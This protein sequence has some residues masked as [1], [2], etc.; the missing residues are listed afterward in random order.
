MTRQA[1]TTVGFTSSRGEQLEGHLLRLARREVVFEVYGPDDV[2]RASEVL[3]KLIVKSGERTVYDGKATVAALVNKPGALTCKVVLD[4]KGIDASGLDPGSS[5]Y[6]EFH[7]QWLAAMR[8]VVA[9]VS[10]L[11]STCSRWL[12][13]LEL[14]FQSQHGDGAEEAGVAFIRETGPRVIQSFN[15]M[16]E[17]FERIAYQID[18]AQRDVHLQFVRSSWSQFFHCTPFGYRTYYKPLGYAGDYEMMNM[19][20]RN[21]PEGT[22]LFAKAMHLLLVS[23]WPAESVRNRIGHLRQALI[24][25]IARVV[26]SNGRARILNVGCGPAWEVQQLIRESALSDHA[27]FT[28]VDFDAET[29]TQVRTTLTDL[30]RAHGRRTGI[31]T[32]Q[33]SVQQLL[34]RALTG[35]KLV[36]GEQYD[37]IYCAGLFDY[38]SDTTCQ[39]LVKV[40]YTYLNPGGR[41]VVA[42]MHDTKPF[43]NFIE[44][45]LDWHLIYR[46][47]AKMW[48]FVPPDPKAETNVIIEPTGVNV[49]LEARNMA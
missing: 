46:D 38:L 15:S 8:V 35:G 19:I 32:V 43:R 25:E 34:K 31:N 22:S 49:F 23:Q 6:A 2:L 26:R 39:S 27:D 1:E 41:L 12:T 16:H 40:F 33:S 48:R 42:N 10:I 13:D 20:H 44:F 7:Q 3:S 11:L 47:A 36:T 4:K 37:L 14:M 24:A 9:D 5:A 17:R 18:P 29:L 45:I 30:A 28:F 21:A